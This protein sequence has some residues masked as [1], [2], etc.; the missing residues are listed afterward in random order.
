M[1][2]QPSNHIE[3]FAEFLIF[4]AFRHNVILLF[5]ALFK[6]SVI[7]SSKIPETVDDVLVVEKKHLLV[8]QGHCCQLQAPGWQ[9]DGLQAENAED[10]LKNLFFLRR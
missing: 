8:G 4:R 9:V 1:P 2:S 3:C 5:D 7:R 6:V 10:D